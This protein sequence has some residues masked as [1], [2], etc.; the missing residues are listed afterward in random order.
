MSVEELWDTYCIPLM[1]NGIVC[2]TAALIVSEA[3]YRQ[4]AIVFM[5]LSVAQI[6]AAIIIITIGVIKDEQR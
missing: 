3:L 2:G 4:T 1:F 6:A 5:V